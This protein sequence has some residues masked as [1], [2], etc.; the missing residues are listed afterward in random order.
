MFA[1]LI[2]FE[3]IKLIKDQIEAVFS[4]QID[5]IEQT[6]QQVIMMGSIL[7]GL[8]VVLMVSVGLYWTNTAVHQYLSGR[9][10]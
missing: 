1:R 4:T 6:N 2:W 7:I 9:P 3:T 8:N 5:D 10:L